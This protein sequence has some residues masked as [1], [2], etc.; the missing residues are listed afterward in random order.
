M[1]DLERKNMRKIK[2]RVCQSREKT[3]SLTPVSCSQLCAFGTLIFL[4][5]GMWNASSMNGPKPGRSEAV[6]A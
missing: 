2:W 5:I 1:I 4:S 6:R 3:E